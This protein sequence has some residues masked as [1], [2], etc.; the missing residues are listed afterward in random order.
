MCVAVIVES[1]KGPSD[2]DLY[3]MNQDNPHGVGLAWAM[4]DLVRY[5]KGLTW[6]QARDLLAKIPRPAL[7]HFRWATHG[8][9]DRAMTHPFPLGRKA[10][11]SR[12]LNGAAKAVLIHNGVWKGYDKFAPAGLDLNRWS[13]TAVAA[14]AAGTFG[15]EILDYVDW[16]TAVARAPGGGRLDITTRGYWEEHEGNLYSNLT[17]QPRERKMSVKV[18]PSGGLEF[19]ED[20]AWTEYFNRTTRQPSHSAYDIED[21]TGEA[22]LAVD[23]FLRWNDEGKLVR[24]KTVAPRDPVPTWLE[25]YEAANEECGNI[26]ARGRK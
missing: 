26:I 19:L 9:L 22:P 6:R 15:E 2:S 14:Y 7:L 18:T 5:R 4:G 10:I 11:T 25:E 23:E 3:H 16:A 8:G 13:D 17:W 21:L 20:D 1:D 24:G 12:K